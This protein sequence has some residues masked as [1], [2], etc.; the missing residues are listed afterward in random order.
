MVAK[1]YLLQLSAFMSKVFD[2][3]TVVAFSIF[4]IQIFIIRLVLY[5]DLR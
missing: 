4:L 2:L 3:F 1:Y 5:V